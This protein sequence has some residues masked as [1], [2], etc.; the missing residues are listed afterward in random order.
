MAASIEAPP[1]FRG[2]T[3][4]QSLHGGEDYELLFTVAPQTRVPAAHEGVKLTRIGIV[5]KGAPGS[6]LL[7]GK[8]LEPLGYDHFRAEC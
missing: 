5:R 4:E 3:L 1:R 7:D 6:I 8:P 2:A